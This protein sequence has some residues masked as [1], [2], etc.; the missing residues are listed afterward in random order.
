MSKGGSSEGELKKKKKKEE[1]DQWAPLQRPDENAS[2]P[3]RMCTRPAPPRAHL[4]P[5]TP[6]SRLV[7]LTL[8]HI[9][10]AVLVQL[11][12]II[13]GAAVCLE[14]GLELVVHVGHD[15]DDQVL[16]ERR[17]ELGEPLEI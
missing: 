12:V 2:T 8:K 7:R 5:W 14:K 1:A 16:D 6:S 11:F 13:H 4:P 17:A 9:P 10:I 3:A 15:K